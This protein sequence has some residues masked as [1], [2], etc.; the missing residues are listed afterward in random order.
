MPPPPLLTSHRGRD[1]VE[2]LPRIC[3]E[4]YATTRCWVP[5][6]NDSYLYILVRWL[7][8]LEMLRTPEVSKFGENFQRKKRQKWI[9]FTN[10]NWRR[11]F[12]G[13]SVSQSQ[14]LEV[15]MVAAGGLWLQLLS[16]FCFIM[17]VNLIRLLSALGDAFLLM[18]IYECLINAGRV[19]VALT[20]SRLQTHI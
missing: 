14:K 6:W 20:P 10:L 12:G 8:K 3:T 18:V 13:E 17:D 7:E 11:K 5:L 1:E 15:N 9:R 4:Y 16:R 19:A 2:M